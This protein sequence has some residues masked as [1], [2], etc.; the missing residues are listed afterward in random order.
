MGLKPA[1]GTQL[2]NTRD[3]ASTGPRDILR[4]QTVISKT[5]RGA[6][7]EALASEYLQ[8]Q[9]LIVIARNL[10]CRAGELD[11]VCLDGQVLVIIEV[12]QRS[13]ADFGGA[14]A[15]VTWRKQRKVIR[16]TQFYSQR[17]AEWR[18]RVL[19]FDVVALQGTPNAAQE[20]TWIKDAFRAT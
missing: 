19:R 14:L 11:L 15:S 13:R 17:Q 2:M 1:T 4:S 16:A 20:I 3:P 5:Q 18:T 8:A 9:G 10:R 12:R 6:A 7:A